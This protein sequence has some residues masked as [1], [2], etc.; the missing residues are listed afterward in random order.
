MFQIRNIPEADLQPILGIHC[1]NILF[2]YARETVSSAIMRAGY[3]PI[4]LAPINFEALYA[5]QLQQ[6]Q[7]A[8]RS[9]RAVADHPDGA[10]IDRAA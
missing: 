6:M 2:P 1:P 8:Q 5:Q 7:A 3:P 10:L 4:N 9:R